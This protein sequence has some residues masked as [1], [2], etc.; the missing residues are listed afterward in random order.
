[1]STLFTSDNYKFEKE[2]LQKA[3]DYYG[4]DLEI[5]SEDQEIA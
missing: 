1:M 3:A 5:D 2:S 4:I